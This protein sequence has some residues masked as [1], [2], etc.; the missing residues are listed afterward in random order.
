M[1]LLNTETL[2]LCE[3]QWGGDGGILSLFHAP[4]WRRMRSGPE[5]WRR[6][7]SFTL[8]SHKHC[9]THSQSWLQRSSRQRET[10]RYWLYASCIA[11]PG[12]WLPYFPFRSSAIKRETCS[13]PVV[14]TLCLLCFIS[15]LHE[16]PCCICVAL[17]FIL[18]FW[19]WLT[20][21][22]K[23]ISICS[24]ESIIQRWRWGNNAG[25]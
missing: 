11:I 10:S 15:Q 6:S 7:G 16:D 9:R 25:Q 21:S 14:T 1:P 22:V 2:P 4:G 19:C 17:L 3:S 24:C 13:Y 23:I 8:P 20:Y 18:S 12:P 5:P